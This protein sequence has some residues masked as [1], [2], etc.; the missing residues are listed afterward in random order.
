M[1]M[2]YSESDDDPPWRKASNP[3]SVEHADADAD[4]EVEDERTLLV[5]METLL[6]DRDRVML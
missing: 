6:P 4:V 2:E 3:P 5:V 1:G